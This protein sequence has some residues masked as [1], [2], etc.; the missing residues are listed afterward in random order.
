MKSK[1]RSGGMPS[2]TNGG[3]Q[4]KFNGCVTTKITPA[5]KGK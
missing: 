2:L 4:D 5:G 3:K 1:P